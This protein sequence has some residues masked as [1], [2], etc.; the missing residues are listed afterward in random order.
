MGCDIHCYIDYDPPGENDHGLVNHL[1]EI[2]V[3]RNY[4]LFNIMAGV[5]GDD[6]TLFEPRG[7]P[8]N[9]SWTTRDHAVLYVNDDL[10]PGERSDD[11]ECSRENAERWNS[12]HEV[13]PRGVGGYTDETKK[14]IYH[15]D[16]HSHSWLNTKEVG[17]VIERCKQLGG[18]TP[19]LVAAHAAMKALD[20]AGCT[21]RFVFWFD[22]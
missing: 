1:C 13:R 11:S 4:M 18:V 15:P 2:N 7:L 12:S 6:Q 19:S 21:A 14:R 16:W 5:R 17:L 22:N 3:G 8:E 10:K 20:D 9:L